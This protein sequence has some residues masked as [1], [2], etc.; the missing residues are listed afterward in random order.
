MRRK[1]HQ[2][3]AVDVL[4]TLV[5]LCAAT[6]TSWLRQT[7]N[8]STTVHPSSMHVPW[9]SFIVELQLKQAPSPAPEHVSHDGSQ[10]THAPLALS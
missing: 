9:L 1:I 2:G 5:T 4:V 3:S 7:P 10:V 6:V 8:P